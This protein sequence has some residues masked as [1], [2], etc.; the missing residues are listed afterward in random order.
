M[1]L[2]FPLREP[3]A[4]APEELE[5][6]DWEGRESGRPWT[7]L[8]EH[9]SAPHSDDVHALAERIAAEPRGVIVCGPTSEDVVADRPRGSRHRPAG[10][11]SR[12]RPPA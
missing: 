3:L 12:S 4:P 8:R 11:C 9:A 10:P 7:E 2:N 5:A 1:H 6:A